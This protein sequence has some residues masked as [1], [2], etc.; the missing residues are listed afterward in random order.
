MRPRG[1]PLRGLYEGNCDDVIIFFWLDDFR[2]VNYNCS[3][4]KV[5]VDILMVELGLVDSRSQ[6]QRLVMA[7]QVRADGEVVKKPSVTVS[8]DAE[9]TIDTRPKYVSRGGDKLAAALERFDI[10]VSEQ[11]CGDV[12]ASTGGFTDCLLHQGAKKVY[13]IDVGQGLLDW[14]LR[15]NAQVV[16]MEGVNARYLKNL[17]E[18][19]SLITIDVSF[20]S[21]KVLLP[22]ILNWFH[23]NGGQVIA[24]IKPQFEA[25]RRETSRGKGVIRDPDV[26]RQVLEGVLSF[27]QEQGYAVNGLMQSPLIGPKGN[28]EF[29][30]HLEYPSHSTQEIQQLVIQVIEEPTHKS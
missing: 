7:G 17:P 5:R 26:H 30:T 1:S 19:V 12:G 23:A 18:P 9:L 28:I 27:A 21:I 15:Q 24:L 25:G 2:K 3:M 10:E 16:V 20:I 11:I 22:V 29:F 4:A 6:A 8:R 14:N 13:A